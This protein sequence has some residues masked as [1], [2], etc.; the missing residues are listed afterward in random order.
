MALAGGGGWKPEGGPRH[1]IAQALED[2]ER[3]AGV[4][5]CGVM[6][7]GRLTIPIQEPQG[8]GREAQ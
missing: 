2:M 3:M 6:D 4:L 8:K 7:L 1:I 5:D